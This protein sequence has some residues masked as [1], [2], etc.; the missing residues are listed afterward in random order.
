MQFLDSE[1]S[2]SLIIPIVDYPNMVRIN[3]IVSQNPW[4]KHRD[5]FREFDKNIREADAKPIFFNRKPVELE[6][7]NIYVLRGSRQIGKTTYIKDLI[8]KLI[9]KGTN[10]DNIL[11]VSSDFFISRRE[12]REAINYFANKNIDKTD[13]YIFIDE[14]TSLKDWNLELKYLSDSGIVDKATTLVT[15]SSASELRKRGELLPGRGL[16]GN[17]YYMRPLSFRDLILQA[18]SHIS[19]VVKDVE[20]RRSLQDL[21]PTLVKNSVSLGSDPDQLVKALHSIAPF[22]R[23]LDYL[24]DIYLRYGGYPFVV[25]EYMAQKLQ[26]RNTMDPKLSEVLVRDILG[27][28]TKLGKQETLVRQILAKIIERYGSRYSFSKLAKDVETTHVTT[29]DYLEALEE[30]F[31][32]TILYAFDFSKKEMKPKGSKKIF[33]Q[34]P[35]V[36]HSIRSFLT[37]RDVNEIV[38]ETLKNEELVSRVVEG[39]V[40]SHFVMSQEVPMMKEPRTFLWFFYNTRGKEIDNVLRIGVT[41]VATEVKYRRKVT[42]R[43]IWRIQQAT[44]NLILTKE[45]LKT[46]GD[47]ILAPVSMFL[48]LL[49]KSE[50]IL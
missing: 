43:D 13:L 42:P 38:E 46:D 15:G 20:F 29:I 33:F 12:L 36:F 27:N 10:A 40:S 32:I 35:F 50:R 14:I 37:G 25:N 3:E 16:E 49:K 39:I 24:F 7:G 9:I 22:K 5:R 47:V 1:L 23:E 21:Q 4:W 6:K 45:D 44:K 28:L 31:I 34:D 17:E 18:T 11:Y 48:A 26:N 8:H 41:Y 30:S 19:D 2:K